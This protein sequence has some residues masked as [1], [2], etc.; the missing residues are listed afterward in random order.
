MIADKGTSAK[1]T[2]TVVEAGRPLIEIQGVRK[3]YVTQEKTVKALAEVNLDIHA[4]EFM[5]F[6]GPSG[7][8][9]STLLNIVAGLLDASEGTVL[10][11]GE[12]LTKPRRDMGFMFQA[13]V[14]LPWR[15]V[16]RNVMMPAEV[17]G[18]PQEEI[19]PKARRIL[20]TVGLGDFLDALPS[21]LSGGMQQRAS[22][23]RVLTYE[24]RVLLMD[25]PFGALDEFTREAMNLELMR[26]AAETG[27][28][29]LFV[30]HNISEAVFLSHRVVVM[31]ARPS[32]VAGVVEVPFEYP[33]TVD[34]MHDPQF[35][36]L[37]FQ[38]R[39]LLGESV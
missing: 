10:V 13:P 31:S 2:K 33:R 20:T 12:H 37:T 34:V 25:E 39:Q 28:T 36:D 3:S 8:G 5:S 21:E 26:I 14:L 38:I 27:I 11:G 32:R 6:V 30:T 24:P 15:S 7:C 1:A 9:K 19:R 29:I 22:L 18:L 35:T 23:A 4:G 16:E 17:F